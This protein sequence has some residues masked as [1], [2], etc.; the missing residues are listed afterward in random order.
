MRDASEDENGVEDPHRGK[1]RFSGTLAS[2]ACSRG[3][4]KLLRDDSEDENGV[5]NSSVEMELVSSPTV[6]YDEV[7]PKEQNSRDE[8]DEVNYLE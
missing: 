4:L 1:E 2:L 5:K 7:S 8:D 3:V 6:E